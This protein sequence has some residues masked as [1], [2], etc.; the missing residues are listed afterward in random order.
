MKMRRV[1]YDRR[2]QFVVSLLTDELWLHTTKQ[3]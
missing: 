2:K 3:W 1:E